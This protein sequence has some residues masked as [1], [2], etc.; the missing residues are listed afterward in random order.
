MSIYPPYKN[1][2]VLCECMHLK[3]S[4]ISS[5][6]K[7]NISLKHLMNRTGAGTVCG[8]CRP[9][10]QESLGEKIWQNVKKVEKEQISVW[11]AC[12]TLY[13]DK[14]N[15]TSRNTGQFITIQG[16]VDNKW[17]TRRYTLIEISIQD[18]F[19]KIIVKKEEKGLFSNW[20]HNEKADKKFIRVSKPMGEGIL[21]KNDNSPIVFL[22][23]GIG[24]TPAISYLKTVSEELEHPVE[25]VHCIKNEKHYINYD[26]LLQ[27]T[28]ENKNIN[29]R[30]HLKETEGRF[31]EKELIKLMEHHK[32]STFFICGPD[33]FNEEIVKYL[34]RQKIKKTNILI[35]SFSAAVSKN[36]QPS[37]TYAYIGLMLFV[38]FLVQDFFVLK[39]PM[40]ETLQMD[41]SYRIYSGIFVLFFIGLQ[42]IRPYNK[43]C[44][45]PRMDACTFKN[46]KI[47]GAFAPLVFF[48][49]SS[50][51]GVGY[52]F[53]LSIV[54]FSNFLVGIFN[55]EH[56]QNAQIRIRFYPKWLFLHIVLSILTVV[57]IALHIYIV[58]AY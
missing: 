32:K 16:Y 52:L 4:E 44:K 47:L 29:I 26:E 48:V 54:Y 50:T 45:I 15:V 9:L 41:N 13:V 7:K 8:G 27:Y 20:L 46:H 49:H 24:I 33:E 23:A 55:Y 35:E 21:L 22:V 38:L 34:N 6:A 17:I 18:N 42:F 30:F 12:F 39:I 14:V 51:F 19:Y 43:A 3:H 36:I 28:A 40:L 1:C 53:F 57:L 31:G 10:L 5:V 37:K 56:I 58:G 11:V 2:D 25:I